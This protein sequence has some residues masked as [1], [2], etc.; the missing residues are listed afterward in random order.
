M[1]NTPLPLCALSASLIHMTPDVGYVCALI[2]LKSKLTLMRAEAFSTLSEELIL[3]DLLFVVVDPGRQ[4]GISIRL[5]V[6]AESASVSANATNKTVYERLD[7]SFVRE[8]VRITA[9]VDVVRVLIYADPVD[10]HRRGEH[11]VVVV[12]ETEVLGYTQVHD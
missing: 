3:G 11:K 10:T 6:P 9:N 7:V 2:L 8:R 5:L 1:T 12:D 4:I